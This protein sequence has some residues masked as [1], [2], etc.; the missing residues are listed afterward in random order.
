[1]INLKKFLNFL[2]SFILIFLINIQY[3]SS[4]SFF[5]ETDKNN[6][7][8]TRKLDMEKEENIPQNI[9]IEKIQINPDNS[10][11]EFYKFLKKKLEQ[12]NLTTSTQEINYSYKTGLRTPY[13]DFKIDSEIEG[14]AKSQNL[15]LN[16]SIFF[17]PD[18]LVNTKEVRQYHLKPKYF[19][20]NVGNIIKIQDENGNI[21]SC[22]F[23]NRDSDKLLIIGEGFTNSR[24][25]MSPFI[26]MFMDYDVVIFD[27]RGQGYD[28]T[29]PLTSLCNFNLVNFLFGI[30]CEKVMLGLQE[31][32]D[33]FTVV[34]YFR[35]K[36]NYKEVTGIGICYSTLIFVK[37]QGIRAEENKQLFNKLILDG[38]WI[39]L[40]NFTEKLSR[41]VKLLFSPQNGGWNKQWLNKKIWF[42]N[43]L[44]TTA[45]ELFGVQFNRVS[46]LDFLPKIK[47]LPIL[48][49][50]GKDDLTISR[51]E[52]E[53]IWNATQTT[54]K[55]AIITSNPHVRNHL[56]QKELYKLICDLFL[57]L[58]HNEFIDCLKNKNNLIQHF[59]GKLRYLY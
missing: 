40:E 19:K 6:E 37:A 22:T 25:V 50:Y 36:K 34:D 24:E 14:F 20:H 8:L 3:S 28:N 29:K 48:F 13:E 4:F 43:F 11:Y 35:N 46:I 59:A 18:F 53:T 9:N 12:Y 30:D 33:V 38:C 42:Q 2:Y 55:T 5:K 31:E 44:I 47:N 1:M 49:F 56:K 26:D 45:E 16:H 27:Y 17:D 7:L 39:S 54:E 52:F 41:D 58:P 51:H 21:V 10:D 15:R 57:E 23:F 32:N